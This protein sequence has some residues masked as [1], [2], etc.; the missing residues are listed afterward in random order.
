MKLKFS[1]IRPSKNNN[2]N[3][4]VTTK[5]TANNID[6]DYNVVH[7]GKVLTIEDINK[8]RSSKYTYLAF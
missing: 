8:N 7:A 2:N 1:K 5:I 4:N 3:K 6:V